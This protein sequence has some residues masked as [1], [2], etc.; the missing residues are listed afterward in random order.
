MFFIA[1]SGRHFQII[2]WTW[3]SRR[4]LKTNWD[5]GICKNEEIRGTVSK[6][7]SLKTIG[8]FIF[9]I[10]LYGPSQ[11]MRIPYSCLI[12]I[13]NF[14]ASFALGSLV[15]RS[16]TRSMPQNMPVPLEIEH[17]D[18]TFMKAFYLRDSS[19]WTKSYLTS[20]IAQCFCFSLFSSTLKSSPIRCECSSKLLFF[21]TSRT[22][23]TAAQATGFPPYYTV[24]V[25]SE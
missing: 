14:N 19:L 25:F 4:K 21:R 6:F 11:F 2:T 9:K 10:F 8:G 17:P 20:P 12:F 5:W 16:L 18:H 15:F 24:L 22:P 7:S 23:R 1:R 3:V 13:T